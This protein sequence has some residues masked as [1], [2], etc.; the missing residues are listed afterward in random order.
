MPEVEVLNFEWENF[1][2]DFSQ[3]LFND[4]DMP[5]LLKR[6]TRTLGSIVKVP[7]ENG[8]HTY[9]RVLGVELAFHDLRTKEEIKDLEQIITSPILFI[10][11]VNYYAITKGL[12]VKVGKISLEDY[13]VN[14]PPQFG[15]N[16]LNPEEFFIEEN[17][18]RRLATKDECKGLERL[19][20]W[21]PEGVEK[22]TER[23][24]CRA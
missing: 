8:F 14:I 17:G 3:Y 5:T 7:L 12:W 13:P 15:Q 4:L 11:T 23:L 22:A 6:Q 21:T 1:V 24:L 9:A 16:P 19:A 2:L 18:F 10:T 20:V